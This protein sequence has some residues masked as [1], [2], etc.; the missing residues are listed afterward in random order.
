MDYFACTTASGET[1]RQPFPFDLPLAKR[2]AFMAAALAAH[3][4]TPAAPKTAPAPTP[5]ED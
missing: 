1:I 5:T 4:T 2:D 3:T